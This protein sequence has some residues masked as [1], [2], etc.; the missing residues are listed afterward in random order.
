M[1][2]SKKLGMISGMPSLLSIG[3][4]EFLE[5]IR[6]EADGTYKN[7]RLMVSKIRNNAGLSAYEIAVQNG[8]VG[9][10]EMWLK[11]LEGKSAYQLA[12]E[13]G[14]VGDETAF[15][16]SLVGPKGKDGDVGKSIFDIAVEEGFLGTEAEFLASLKGKSAYQSWLDVGNTG[17]ETDFL[18]A[19]QG[20][21]G[22]DGEQGKDGKDGIAGE[23]GESA[24]EG[25][26]RY[27]YVGTEEEFYESL[28]K[29]KGGG[30]VFIIDVTPQS[31]TENVGAKVYEVDDTSLKTCLSTTTAVVVKVLA[32][33]GH[34]KY[35]PSITVNGNPVTIAAKPDAPLFEGSI[36]VTLDAD[37]VIHAEHED[38]AEWTTVVTLDAPPVITSATFKTAYP[39]GQT[40]A[41][42]DDV[43]KVGFVV[44]SPVVAYEIENFGALKASAGTFASTSAA[45]ISAD[46]SVA[47]R[48]NTT[49][50]HGFRIRVRKATGA[51]SAWFASTS[52]GTADLVNTIKLNNTYP[53]IT[54][55]SVLYP[56]GQTALKGSEAATVNHTVTSYDTVSY[57]ST[58]LAINAP[59][60]YAPAKGVTR[61]S[62]SYNIATDNFIVTAKRNAN[63]A[64]TVKGTVV[65]IADGTPVISVS[66]PAAR[67]RS[68]GNN[69]T[70][71]QQH[72]ITI[73]STQA[74]SEAPTMNAPEGTWT[75]AAFTSNAAKTVWTRRL[76]VHDTNVKGSY[77]WNSLSAKSMSGRTIT[78]ITAGGTY[79]LGGFV[80]RT[81]AVSAYPNRE[82][83]I[84]TTV[85]DTSKLRCTNLSKGSTGTLNF[86]YQASLASA[87]DR[88][89]ITGPTG[90]ANNK[91]NLWY[92]ADAA[93]ATSN[94]GGTM[95]IEL[96]EVV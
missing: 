79:V 83:V 16:E 56:V 81:L 44:D 85:S 59:T 80:F 72:T 14:F 40:E 29:G 34:T 46:Q 89:S 70:A 1:A 73:T 57:A 45:T 8:Y 77:N 51:W 5:V 48:G 22:I 55:G 53:T 37:G 82:A 66:T 49:T 42:A 26:V 36:L 95:Q 58:E 24:Y 65:A 76:Q 92:N 17:T 84:G 11:S 74:L 68:G 21:P 78:A 90:V 28:K 63:G 30:A 38:G 86:T 52:T 23:D 15:L 12:V 62:G 6:L 39:A 60:V 9:T 4:E 10:A 13:L 50:A 54:F 91:G 94:T 87:A 69:G 64:S 75:D 7:Y 88:Y 3:G 31:P 25:A 93:N 19:I 33:T 41:K 35:R 71:V 96:E 2:E 32:I 67:L 27:G 47:D 18:Q 61:Q 43:F 20:P